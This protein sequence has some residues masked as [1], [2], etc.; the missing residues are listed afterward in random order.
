MPCNVAL[1]TTSYRKLLLVLLT[2]WKQKW[3]AINSSVWK[4]KTVNLHKS[5]KPNEI[6]SKKKNKQFF[7][8]ATIYRFLENFPPFAIIFLFLNLF[9]ACQVASYTISCKKLWAK[10]STKLFLPNF[11]VIFS[12]ISGSNQTEFP[13]KVPFSVLSC[14]QW[15]FRFILAQAGVTFNT[16]TYFSEYNSY[17]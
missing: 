9:I 4:T 14:V 13:W 5:L 15:T 11:K 10:I 8:L 7:G 3:Q 6:F 17:L 16:E 2:S 1:C 12:L